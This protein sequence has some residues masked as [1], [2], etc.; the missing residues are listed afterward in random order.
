MQLS[1][2]PNLRHLLSPDYRSREPETPKRGQRKRGERS[3]DI[4]RSVPAAGAAKTVVRKVPEDL[5]LPEGHLRPLVVDASAARTSVNRVERDD[6]AR[7]VERSSE[8]PDAPTM[9]TCVVAQHGVSDLDRTAVVAQT[10]SFDQSSVG[11]DDASR[12]THR[13]PILYPSVADGDAVVQNR[14]VNDGR[15]SLVVDS[16]GQVGDIP[17]YG[18]F[19]ENELAVIEDSA[20]AQFAVV[21][22]NAVS[23]NGGTVIDDPSDLCVV[24]DHGTAVE[25]H[26]PVVQDAADP[27]PAEAVVGDAA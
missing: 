22:D 13:A 27:V 14:R 16:A 25:R 4:R 19:A 5:R 3:S 20:R 21:G 23:E 26:R 24:A 10:P 2:Q 18:A 15:L 6:T 17:G 12:D 7:Q 11:G 8:G 9:T 1:A